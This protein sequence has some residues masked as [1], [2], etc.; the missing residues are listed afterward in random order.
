MPRANRH[1]MVGHAWH[2]THRCHRKEFLLKFAKDRQTWINWL[3][4]AKKRY[5]QVILNYLAASN[6]RHLLIHDRDGGEVIPKSVQLAAGRT[7]QAYNQRKRR[8]GAYWE[9]RYPATAVQTDQHLVQC[10]VYL[11]LNRVRAGGVKHPW[12]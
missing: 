11:D 7:A 8:I 5:G 9:D 2:I 12:Q 1:S 6:H 4:E 3:F 10:I